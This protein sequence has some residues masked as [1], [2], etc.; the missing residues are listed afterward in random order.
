M[1][2]CAYTQVRAHGRANVRTRGMHL[3]PQ[4]CVFAFKPRQG[5]HIIRSSSSNLSNLVFGMRVDLRA[6][7]DARSTPRARGNHT[8]DATHAHASYQVSQKCAMDH[9]IF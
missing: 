5:V 3:P 8:H 4:L 1:Y 6:D 2:T 7:A 9:I